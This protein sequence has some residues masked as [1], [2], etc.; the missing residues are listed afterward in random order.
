L[1]ASIRTVASPIRFWT[2]M[3]SSSTSSPSA[4]STISGRAAAG[5]PSVAY[6]FLLVTDRYPPFQLSP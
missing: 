2:G 4:S 3:I 1:Y 6:A 5:R